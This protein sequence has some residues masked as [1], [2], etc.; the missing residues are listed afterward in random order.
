MS[1]KFFFFESSGQKGCVNLALVRNIY[2]QK[3]GPYHSMMMMYDQS[4]GTALQGTKDVVE[5]AVD[6]LYKFMA[7]EKTALKIKFPALDPVATSSTAAK[8]RKK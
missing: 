2:T 8:K 6:E 4:S 3:N 1:H 7:S 5:K